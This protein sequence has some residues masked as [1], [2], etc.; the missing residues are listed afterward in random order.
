MGC[1]SR[2]SAKRRCMKCV[3]AAGGTHTQ[4]LRHLVPRSL[5]TFLSLAR[6][7][8]EVLNIVRSEIHG[9]GTLFTYNKE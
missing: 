9:R 6:D 2:I 3:R 8:S 1:L 7:G 5:P 4:A